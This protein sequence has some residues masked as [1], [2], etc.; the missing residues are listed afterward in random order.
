MCLSNLK[1]SDK[2]THLLFLASASLKSY[3]LLTPGRIQVL[4]DS[5]SSKCD[6]ACENYIYFALSY[7]LSISL[8]VPSGTLVLICSL[9]NQL[10]PKLSLHWNNYYTN[11]QVYE[12]NPSSSLI[13]LYSLSA[14]IIA[15]SLV[16]QNLLG[17]ILR[18]GYLLRKVMTKDFLN[19]SVWHRTD[20]DRKFVSI[21]RIP[22]SYQVGAQ[23]ML[24]GRRNQILNWMLSKLFVNYQQNPSCWSVSQMLKV[25]YLADLAY[26]NWFPPRS[27]FI[28]QQ[29]LRDHLLDQT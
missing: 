13:Y 5:I 22:E 4:N 17:V 14:R 21:I 1:C 11:N 6:E 2:S 20:W 23:I 15:L 24:A 16:S 3:F 19:L 27:E 10:L 26:Q 9:V 28:S 8:S 25:K 12:F 7:P 29:I 18:W